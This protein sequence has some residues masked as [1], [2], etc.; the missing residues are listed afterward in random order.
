[1]TTPAATTTTSA[2]AST[3]FNL[4]DEPWIVALDTDGCNRTVSLLQV[5]RE[6][7]TIRRLAGELPTQDAAILRL[8]LAILYRAL[9]VAGDEEERA[10]VWK[11][12]WGGGLPLEHI[13]DH[14]ERYRDRFD[15]LHPDHPFFQVADLHTAS[16][17]TSG[18]ATLIADLPPH[19]FFTNR[20][21]EGAETLSFGEAARWLVHCQ[22]YDISGIKS[23]AVGDDRVKGGKGY[24][25]GTG[26]A[27][28]L[29]MIVLEGR[30]LAE[31]L[32]LNLVL[33]IESSDDDLAPW[34]VDQ[35]TAAAT[36]ADSPR[37]P[38][39]AMTWQVRR[40]RLP[41]QDGRVIDAV[42]ANGDKIRLRNQHRVEPMTGWRSSP[43]QAK[44]H[45]E[46]L[47]YMP[48]AHLPGRLMWRGLGSLIAAA[49]VDA[50][51]GK[52]ADAL[53][54]S[55]ISWVGR[56]RSF[57][58]LPADYP[59]ALHVVGCIYGTQNA[60]V[61]TVVSDRM[62]VQA[63]LL[64]SQVLQDAAVRAATL[65]EG[66][67][68]RLRWLASDLAAAA[69][70]DGAGDADRAN[71][72]AYQRID[73]LFRAWLRELNRDEAQD[74]ET[75]WQ[76]QMR[77]VAQELADELYAGASTAAVIGRVVEDGNGRARRLD[78]AGAHR[79]FHRRLRD[80]LAADE[81]S[82]KKHATP[83]EDS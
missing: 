47:A 60:V 52:A 75:V 4:L 58:C 40:V 31:T 59:V 9:P 14:L 69:G 11:S 67:V 43:T 38:A 19:R 64:H 30:S 70:R 18:L 17:N 79:T 73:P 76:Q 12:W 13:E 20:A 5:L 15:L 61:E 28:N 41:A 35:W 56:L 48:R 21:G 26:W 46:P 1:M 82:T 3:S 10:Q 36:G 39:Q 83:E 49:P 74:H 44:A 7:H 23:G 78:A 6:A 68:A 37:G 65:A 62:L 34:E 66:I 24:P 80:V 33:T 16:G 81:T 2:T 42:I 77:A 51:V 63:E 53:V 71:D 27:G 8:L 54:A 22:A 72:L 25:I 45:G 32:L 50:G 29:G 55:T 57:G